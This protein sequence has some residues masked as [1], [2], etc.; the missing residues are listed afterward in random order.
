[1]F[2]CSS[3]IFYNNSKFRYLCGAFS[4]LTVSISSSVTLTSLQSKF[5]VLL[6]C[7]AWPSI[8]VILVPTLLGSEDTHPLHRVSKS[9]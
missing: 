7:A 9:D 6:A 4:V 1:M 5:F 8:S 2:V 3:A